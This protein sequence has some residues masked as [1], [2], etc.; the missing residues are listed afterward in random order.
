LALSATTAPASRLI[1]TITGVFKPTSG[2]MFVRDKEI[3]LEA[4][5]V[6]KA[7]HLSIETVY[8]DSRSVR[9]AVRARI[10]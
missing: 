10:G 5:S 8:Q 6:G 7:H 9:G 2:R 4:Y 1:K 3:D